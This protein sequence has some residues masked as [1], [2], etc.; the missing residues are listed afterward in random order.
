[1]IIGNKNAVTYKEIFP[2]IKQNKLWV[3]NTPMSTDMMFD[4]SEEFA[5]ELVKNKNEGSAYKLIRGVV[6]ARAQAIW[7]TNLDITKRHEDLILYKT[8]T[9]KDYPKYDNYDAINVDK[10][11]EIQK[12]VT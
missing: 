1:V 7:F 3:G 12:K 10:T 5:Q 6:K 2:L 8:Y 11:K 9:P 4:V